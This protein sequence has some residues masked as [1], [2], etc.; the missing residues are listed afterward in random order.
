MTAVYVLGG[1]LAGFILSTILFRLT[2]GWEEERATVK[3]TFGDWGKGFDAGY[4]AAAGHYQ[5]YK[6]GFYDGWRACE[7]KSTGGGEG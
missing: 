3:D 5:D 6:K 7:K 4:D 1:Y 2:K